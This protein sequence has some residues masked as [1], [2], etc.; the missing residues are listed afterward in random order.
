MRKL[1]NVDNLEMQTL[2]IYHSFQFQF[3]HSNI[4]LNLS[5]LISHIMNHLVPPRP[6]CVFLTSIESGCFWVILYISKL[7]LQ[8]AFDWC[9]KHRD[10]V[11]TQNT[12]HDC[13]YPFLQ[14]PLYIKSTKYIFHFK[15]KK[16]SNGNILTILL[17]IKKCHVPYFQILWKK[18]YFNRT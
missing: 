15:K 17:C 7:V 4:C 8:L 6:L 11:I 9:C 18:N 3:L 12:L 5:R 10:K 1:K 14:E 13:K 16:I 2:A